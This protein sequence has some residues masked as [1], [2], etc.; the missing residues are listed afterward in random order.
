MQAVNIIVAHGMRADSNMLSKWSRNARGKYFAQSGNLLEEVNL[1][2]GLKA[3][4]G[5]FASVRAATGR[6]LLNGQVK[7]IAVWEA[8][9]LPDI[10]TAMKLEGVPLFEQSRRLHGVFVRVT[11]LNNRLKK[12]SGFAKRGDGHSEPHL[13]DSAMMLPILMSSNSSKRL[14]QTRSGLLWLITS[15]RIMERD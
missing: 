9:P 2:G 7:H 12:I 3:F 11:H 10:L 8:L 4:R 1:V 5:F 13:Q 15:L 6:I 14:R